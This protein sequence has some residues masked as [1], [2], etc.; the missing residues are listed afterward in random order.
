MVFHFQKLTV[1]IN[2]NKGKK[3]FCMPTNFRRLFVHTSLLSVKRT[4]NLLLERGGGGGEE[5]K[6]YPHPPKGRE[7]CYR[8]RQNCTASFLGRVGVGSIIPS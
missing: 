6:A 5:E 3:L 2:N 7:L 1:S 4:G 8:L